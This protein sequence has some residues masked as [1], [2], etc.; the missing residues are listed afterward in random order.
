M[1]FG[2]LVKRINNNVQEVKA[3]GSSVM[4]RHVY[5]NYP[6]ANKTGSNYIQLNTRFGRMY[7]R[8]T[9]SDNIVMSKIFVDRE[10]DLDKLPQGARIRAVYESILSMGKT[11]LIVDAGGNIGL[12][13]RFFA[14]A[15]PRAHVVSIEPDPN[16]CVVARKNAEGFTN[17]EVIEAAIGSKAGYVSLQVE[18]NASWA[19]RTER[20]EHGTPVVTV[21]EIKNRHANSQILI[22]K[23]D[24]EGFESDL[25]S[26]N[27]DWIDETT[28]IVIEPHDWMI[29][30]AGTSRTLQQAV[31]QGD[32]EILILGENLALVK[33]D[34]AVAEL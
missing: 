2:S 33:R 10:Y 29:P 25:F 26:S 6:S 9:D 11:P 23:I 15:Y 24:I 34:A 5:R 4:M 3:L 28:A 19:T 17:I 7:L 16:N 20:S 30:G 31:M 32:R 22:V 14:L 18:N 8:P 27:L 12:A 21:G 1:N 13:A